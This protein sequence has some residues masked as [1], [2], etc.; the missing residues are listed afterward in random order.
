M[1]HNGPAIFNGMFKLITITLAFVGLA[2]WTAG[3]IEA[4]SRSDSAL[5]QILDQDLVTRLE[6]RG[7]GPY[8]GGRSTAV[9]GIPGK[10]NEF[11]MGTTGGGVWKTVDGGVSWKNLSDGS[12]G[13]ASIGALAVAS[14]DPNVVYAGTG[15]ACPR[16]NVSPG[17][18]MYRSTDGGKSW[19]RIGLEEAGQIARIRVHPK[20]PDQLWVAAL[21]HIFG[22]NDQRGV[23]HSKDGGKNWDRVLFVSDKA[24]AVDLA[25][26][27]DNPRVPICFYLANRAQTL[28]AY[29]RR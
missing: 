16:G 17:D 8:R 29:F 5:H 19:I 27:S 22:P 9:A 18:G 26:S 14:S 24:G 23:F 4:S 3:V 13:A 20:D 6:F 12:I 7:I 2:S 10:P 11:F 15:S 21:G 28:D 25:I 1:N